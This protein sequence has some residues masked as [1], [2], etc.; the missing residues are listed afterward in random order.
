MQ[1]VF[2]SECLGGHTDFF[3]AASPAPLA[4]QAGPLKRLGAPLEATAPV[5]LVLTLPV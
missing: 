5:A 3:E 2:L 1:R 4:D